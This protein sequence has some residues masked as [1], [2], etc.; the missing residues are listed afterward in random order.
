MC[1]C[2]I[3]TCHCFVIHSSREN[4]YS[5]TSMA[6]TSLVA[7]QCIRNMGSSRP[8]APGQE[9]NGDNLGKPFDLLYNN[10]ILSALVRIASM[11]RF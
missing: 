4:Q 7:W 5:K 8:L 1:I 11:R 10:G 3:Y 9:A 2:I 6:G